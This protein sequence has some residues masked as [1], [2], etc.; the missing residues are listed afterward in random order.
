MSNAMH[1]VSLAAFLD[2]GGYGLYV[3]GSVLAA[4]AAMV[5]EAWSLRRRHAQALK[6]IRQLVTARDA[7]EFTS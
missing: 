4:F 6:Q 1:W 3:W 5:L 2:M 7:G